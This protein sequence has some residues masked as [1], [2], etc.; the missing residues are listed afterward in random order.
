MNWKH[1]F[2][3]VLVLS[4]V[5]VIVALISPHNVIPVPVV[6]AE[7]D[8]RVIGLAGQDIRVTVVSTPEA[9]AKGLGGRSGLAA[10]EGM[11]F[12]FETDAKYR[13]WMK[14][15][16]FSIDMLWLSETGEVVDMRESVSPATY[17][18]VFTP[19]APARYVL[20]LPAGFAEAYSVKVGDIVRL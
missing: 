3:T 5:V 14:D 13:F 12:V 1:T 4:A 6:P 16:L 2:Q 8:V 10:D 11:L 18:E 7:T 19:N 20:E 17:P 15:M 9:R